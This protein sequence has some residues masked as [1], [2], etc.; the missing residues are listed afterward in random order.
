MSRPTYMKIDLAALRYNLQR[1]RELAPG[2]SV[3][4][5]VKANA[6]GHGIARVAHALPMADA[7]GVASLEEGL[8]LR[9]AGITQP[10]VLMEGLFYPEEIEEAAKH[11]FTLVVHHVPHVEM[12]EKAK[13][14]NPFNVWL[15]INTG[16]HRL[17]IDPAALP[18]V[19]QRLAAAQ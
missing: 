8:I 9:D 15:K 5:M 14:D 7:L 6:Y 16:M 12:L 19:Y 3:I 18:E 1:V 10:I 13:V 17:G 4:A 2:R 11:H